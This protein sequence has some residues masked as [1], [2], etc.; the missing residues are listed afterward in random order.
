MQPFPFLGQIQ[1]DQAAIAQAEAE[2]ASAQQT[3]LPD[4]DD[5][6]L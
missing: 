5:D 2:L 3:A 6:D 1:M 4:D